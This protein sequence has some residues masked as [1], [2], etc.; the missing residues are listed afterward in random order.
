MAALGRRF[1]RSSE[2]D[3]EFWALRDVS[4]DV[5]PGEVVGIVGRNGAGKSTLLKILSRITK[6]TAGRVALRGRVGSLLEVGTGF[7]PELTGRENV[8]LNGSVL[9]MSRKE[10]ARKFDEVIAFAE[11]ERFLN[12][13][14]K[15]Y[16]S[17]MHVRLAFAVAAHLEPEILIVDEVLAVGDAAFQK[18]CLGKMNEIS[19]GGRTVLVVSH[20]TAV[21]SSLCTSGVVLDRGE[22]KA[23]GPIA[24]CL[25]AYAGGILS[26]LPTAV[27]LSR[28]SHKPSQLVRI[29]LVDGNGRPTSRFE[30]GDRLAIRATFTSDVP[31]RTPR[32][33]LV[34]AAET[35]ERVLNTNMH[36]LPSNEPATPLRTGVI[37]CDLGAVPLM[38][39]K[40]LVS[41]WFG[42][43]GQEH[44]MIPDAIGFEVS[45]RDA[46][47]L[48]RLP[49]TGASPMWWPATFR[50]EAEDED[51]GA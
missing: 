15:R 9:G 11:V 44:E 31:T 4:F 12:T 36:Y 42:T 43:H 7:H 29:E 6:P 19:R 33:G 16:S 30:Y 28:Q 39:G 14:V 50:V 10:V 46:W 20:N 5:M 25:R 23:T 37:T 40:Y 3:G 2:V 8:F 24:Q 22:V 35:G 21:L 47:G 27:D 18:K 41:F 13:P 48:G 51:H 34:I 38:A 49:P 1:R 32:L 17:G 45:E 26:D